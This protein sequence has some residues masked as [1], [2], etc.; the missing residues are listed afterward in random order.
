MVGKSLEERRRVIWARCREDPAWDPAVEL[1]DAQH[2]SGKQA[3]QQK[4]EDKGHEAGE[5]DGKGDSDEGTGAAKSPFKVTSSGLL[6]QLPGR[7]GLLSD[8]PSQAWKALSVGAGML[9]SG[10]GLRSM[11]Y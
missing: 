5:E 7:S 8:A 11:A 4:E 1:R 3:Q 9:M 10:N 6:R 2:A